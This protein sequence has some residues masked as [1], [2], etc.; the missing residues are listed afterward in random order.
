M[1]HEGKYIYGI[2][3]TE[4][5][6]NF[7]PIGIGGKRDEVVTIGV[8][9]LAA[10]ISNSALDHYAASR[11]NLQGHTKVIEKVF[12]NFTIL[13]LQFCT[14]AESTDEILNFLEK[15]RRELNNHLKDLEG[16]VEVGIKIIWKNMKKIFDEIAQENKVIHKLKE[17]GVKGGGQSALIH[18]GE[19]VEAALEEKKAVEGED[20][21][22]PLKKGPVT[23]KEGEKKTEDRVSEARFLP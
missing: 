16:K 21:L 5:A 22:R 2:I 10:V 15:N 12:E 6:P 13:P 23:C 20:Y 3:A 4:E 19:L 9:G 17:K 14:V 7:G 8:K 1:P 11:E 18:A